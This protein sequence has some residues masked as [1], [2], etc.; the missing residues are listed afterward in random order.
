MADRQR[1]TVSTICLELPDP[2]EDAPLFT[3]EENLAT[4]QRFLEEAGR[5]GSD[6]VCLPE[7]FATKRTANQ[8]Q[9]EVI[10][11]GPIS[12]ML[13]GQAAR[14]GM[15]V[16]GSLY[17]RVGEVTYNSA[18]L[19]DRRGGHLGS[20]HKVHLAKGEAKWAAA[21]DSYPVFDTDFGRVGCLVC[22][23]LNFPEAACSLALDGAEII[24]WPTMFS[25]PRGHVTDVLTRARAIENQVFLVSANYTQKG[26][27]PAAVHF[28]R[29][30]VIDWDGMTL[31][32]TGRRAGLATAVISLEESRRGFGSP[33]LPEDR[34]PETYGR[35]LQ[36]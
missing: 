8:G 32:D 3:R 16:V 27:D 20:Y 29:S 1:V 22:F 14:W 10:G 25:Q 26:L 28:G 13:S 11:R 12:A 34:R 5:R 7:V 4:G 2:N 35:L 36:P 31:A 17:E 24:F 23:D 21:G 6:I 30:A 18:A 15:Y 19:F 9:A 33:K